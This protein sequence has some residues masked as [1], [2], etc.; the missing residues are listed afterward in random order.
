MRRYAGLVSG[1]AALC[2]LV[3]AVAAAV[4]AAPARA[5]VSAAAEQITSYDVGIAI[6]RDGSILVQ[7]QIVYDIG[8]NERHG[9]FRD[10]P[11]R[12]RY[13]SR[14]DRIE[15]VD[16]REVSS[17]D[18]PDRYRVAD[19]GSS[20]RITIMDPGQLI[21]GRHTYRISYLVHDSLNAF[22]DHDELYWNAIGAQW[23]VPIDRTTVRVTAPA[24]L[25]RAA[26]YAGP[27][28]STGRCEQAGIADGA[29][30][31]TQTGLLPHEALTVAAAI[32]KGAVA[33]PHLVLREQWTLQRAFTAA[34]AT[35]AASGGLLVLL[36]AGGLVLARR[37]RAISA[38]GAGPAFASREPA[39]QPV[40]PEGVPPGLAGALTGRGV[41]L[42]EHVTATM[43]DL[44]VRG[45]LRIE[46]AAQQKR[47]PVPPDW[48][49]VRL[50]KA[51]GLLEYEQAVLDGLFKDA[52]TGS[53]KTSVLLSKSGGAYAVLRQARDAMYR[54]MTARGWY[55]ARPDRV[56]R[57]WGL[58]SVALLGAGLA[59]EIPAVILTDLGLVPLPL[60]LAALTLAALI[61]KM[62]VRTAAGN[63]LARQAHGF[64]SY[65]KTPAMQ[66]ACPAGQPGLLYGYIPHAI[67]FRSSVLTASFSHGRRKVGGVLSAGSWLARAARMAGLW[68]WPKT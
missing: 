31:F 12:S 23:D 56:R 68:Q 44:A 57:I 37:R 52:E 35:L 55:T 29:A 1:F 65:L 4:L 36:V 48:R 6:Q 22:A 40:P 21:T 41:V 67:A 25:T 13:N 49:L 27:P 28:G 9:I 30:R 45:Y 14:Y 39:M 58:I 51:G 32:P 19:N 26:C 16:V 66:Q 38:S 18:A 61:P 5:A 11:V 63:D 34:P 33:A 43:V 8:A 50:G 3:L 15:S 42:P 64:R 24:A 46:D 10:I 7:E 60:V 53:G 54:E 59:A 2:A 17:P 20:V 47:R 62:P